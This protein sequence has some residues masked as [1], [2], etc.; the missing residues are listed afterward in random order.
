MVDYVSQLFDHSPL[1]HTMIVIRTVA[2][3]SP[4]TAQARLTRSRL[5]ARSRG[6]CHTELQRRLSIARTLRAV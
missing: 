5:V 3:T 4:A 6:R 2:E 1:E